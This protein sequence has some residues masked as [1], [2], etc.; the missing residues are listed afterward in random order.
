MSNE[1][2]LPWVSR[3]I[4]DDDDGFREVV[5]AKEYLIGIF[6]T[7]IA[8]H[9]VKCVN[10]HEGLVEALTIFVQHF[11]DPFQCARTALAAA[12]GEQK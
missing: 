8:T 4:D 6:P 9:I 7:H 3:I 10:A 11:G 2:N 5:D 12:T 1:M